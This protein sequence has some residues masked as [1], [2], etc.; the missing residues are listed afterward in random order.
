[1]TARV[2]RLAL[3]LV[4]SGAF[5]SATGVRAQS[6]FSHQIPIKV[7]KGANGIQ[8]ELALVYDPDYG[9]GIVGMGW[10]LQGLSAITRVNYGNGITY[11]DSDTY[12]HSQ[13]GILIA[14]KDASNSY[15]SKKESFSKLV[16]TG[17]CGNGPCSWVA[18]DRSG[19]K[20]YY[21]TTPDSSLLGQGK[22]GTVRTWALS[23]V[24]DLFGNNYTI[25]YQN[26]AA[27]G[28]LYPVLITYTMG[29][30]LNTYRTI[31]IQY[32]NR[33]G[34]DPGYYASVFQQMTQR[35]KWISVYSGGTLI[36]KYR[37][38]YAYTWPSQPVA[39]QEYGSNGNDSACSA[40]PPPDACALPA[41]TFA[42]QPNAPAPVGPAFTQWGDG[43]PAR[44]RFGDFNGDGKTDVMWVDGLG[45]VYILI[46]TGSGFVAYPGSGRSSNGTPLTQW[47]DGNPARYRIGD[48]N[49]DGK[50][51]VM[52]VDSLGNMYVLASTGSG[53]VAYPGS[54]R[55]SSG[56]PFTQWGDGNPDRYRFGD[57]NG[58]GKTDVM[59][60]DGV[61]NL[62]VTLSTG[63]GFAPIGH[64]QWGD[65]TP[66]RYQLGDFNGDGKT[67]V[68]WVDSLGNVYVLI[69]MGSGFV[70]YP[71]SG[72]SSNGTPF[73]QWGD[74]N[75]TRYLLGDFNGDGK[76][77]VMWVDSLGN[78][79]VLVST[80]SGF[81]AY[82]G[83]GTSSN[84][85]PFTPWGNGDP[86]RYRIGEF[87]GDGKTDLMWIDGVG[88]LNVDLSTGKGF[89]NIGSP[90]W[91]DG[92]PARY[93]LGDFNGDGTTDVV[94]VDAKGYICVHLT[95][96]TDATLASANNGMGGTV[97]VA[98]APAPQVPGAIMPL[99]IVVPG[100][101]S[102][103]SPR[104]LVTSV[105]TSDGRGGSYTTRYSYGDRRW[106]PGT[107]P[108]QR[109]LGF[110]WIT[111]VE[112]TGQSTTTVYNQDPGKE[113]TVREVRE[114][115]S[116]GMLVKRTVKTYDVVNPASGTELALETS[117]TSESYQL[118]T[119]QSNGS[120]SNFGYGVVTTTTYDSYAN[121]LTKS[122]ASEQNDLP[123]VVT[124]TTYAAPDTTNWILGRVTD[125]VVSSGTTPLR[126]QHFTWTNNSIT[127]SAN[128]WA[129]KQKWLTTSYVYDVY[130]NLLS[131]TLPQAADGAVRRTTTAYD[132]VFNAYPVTVTDAL[133]HTTRMTNGADGQLA[134]VVGPNGDTTTYVYDANWRKAV[135]TRPDGGTT[136]YVYGALGK[137]GS[138]YVSTTTSVDATHA[139][140]QTEWF[141]GSGF[142]YRKESTGPC[143]D[144]VVAIQRL[145]DAVG[146]L[147]QESA[148]Y[149]HGGTVNSTTYGYD[150]AGRLSSV[151][152]PDGKVTQY[153]YDSVARTRSRTDANGNATVQF[154]DAFERIA[155]VVDPA[156][157]SVS[158]T[159]D[160]LSNLA[161]VTTGGGATSIAYDSLGQRT[162]INVPQLGTTLF[163][164]DEVGNVVQTSRNGKTVA[165][166][167]DALNRV[168][169]KQPASEP[170]VT[171]TYDDSSHANGIGRLTSVADAAGVL[172]LAYSAAGQLATS[173][174][175]IDGAS[176][177]TASTYDQVGRITHLVYPDSSYADYSW[178][179]ATLASVSLNGAP[180]ATW[181]S[182]DPA[183]RP[184]GLTYGNQVTTTYGYDASDMGLVASLRTSRGSTDLQNNTYDWYTPPNTGGIN[185]GSIADKRAN[186][187]VG[188][189]NGDESQTFAYDAIYRLTQATGVWG[190]KAYA[191]DGLGNPT[192]FGG[193]IPRTFSFT[194]TQVTSGTGLTNVIYD[195]SGNMTH[196]TIDGIDWDY[197]WT[198]EN[199][200][201]TLSKGGAALLAM[202][203]D[204]SGERV[205][206]VYSPPGSASVT[207]HYVGDLYERRDYGDGSPQRHT[208]NVF[209]NGRLIASVTRTGSI[210]T[211]LNDGSA[212][213]MESAVASLYSWRSARG[214]IQGGLHL[215][216]AL[217]SNP[218]A[219]G[220]AWLLA[221]ASFAGW[222]LFRLAR[223]DRSASAFARAPR[224]GFAASTV[225]VVFTT[226]ACSN[227]SQTGSAPRRPLAGGAY[228]TLGPGV[229]ILY[230]HPNLVGSST[231]ITDSTGTEVER[232]S[233]LPFGELSPSNS[234]GADAV[235]R[236]FGGKEHDDEAALV[237]FGARYYEPQIGRF[238]SAD[239][240]IP[241]PL[242]LQSH[243][244]YSFVR[245]NP[246]NRVDPSG[247]DD[248]S[249]VDVSLVGIGGAAWG[250]GPEVA[251]PVDVVIGADLVAS[252]IYSWAN[253]GGGTF[254]DAVVNAVDRAVNWV[255]DLFS[256]G[257]HHR[258]SAAGGAC[259]IQSPLPALAG[260]TSPGSSGSSG[261]TGALEPA[262][263]DPSP[264]SPGAVGPATTAAA[265]GTL[266]QAQDAAR[267][268]DAFE[269]DKGLTYCNKATLAIARD[270]GAPTGPLTQA[271]GT[272]AYANT[273][274]AAL[275]T[276]TQYHEVTPMEAQQLANEGRFVIGS[277]INPNPQ[278][279]G[280]IATVRPGDVAG[281]PA[282]AGTGPLMNDIGAARWVAP[283]S[284]VFPNWLLPPRFYTPN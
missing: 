215:L 263:T 80:G 223:R 273:Q 10:Q 62:N 37:L 103:R 109:D 45:N 83:S 190:T 12:E 86:A 162:S 63:S 230:Y 283:A 186:K 179:G 188:G 116:T 225:V 120:Y 6:M 36:R 251:I 155:S 134:S 13:V 101:I 261:S 157:R 105:T 130:G 193:L 254:N 94:W 163:T 89:R 185:L 32:E 43:N 206:K 276:S 268:S 16:S 108:Q 210:V 156:S 228:A 79:Y 264:G 277:A 2:M 197:T 147:W 93:Q 40:M 192:T 260:L 50:T 203:Y 68:M 201:A 144:G 124:T 4:A 189:V 113:R 104:R 111:R 265:R 196:K 9:N 48:F 23:Q 198:V 183:G 165:F 154:I 35:L 227:G 90:Q 54:G 234:S 28:Q 204:A 118:G 257:G 11:T 66:A 253:P 39:V 137:P 61:G 26:D 117:S 176:F 110:G 72:T 112:P 229:G 97:V 271:N 77:D 187:I 249:A 64:T 95:A 125:V 143:A 122:V 115:S 81:V 270:V 178:S 200:L 208:I 182:Y 278:L 107:I 161:G 221:F 236:K 146:R 75:P 148:P 238:L 246:I 282:R 243:N 152:T 174:R 141:D 21:G 164:F 239:T 281:D 76:A 127:S 15:R 18:Y 280:H 136:T 220:V 96:A 217:A 44:Y 245:N 99:S 51:D 132:A 244:R 211:A 231:V 172:N 140:T 38:D 131:Y 100:S 267:S 25:A 84:G 240:I 1:V 135:V 17:R 167:F 222:T 171:Y 85:T 226:V 29:P 70:A 102:T 3:S 181:T 92:T 114:Y 275:A 159:Y 33:S 7:P 42:Y 30:G 168:M 55:S 150:V 58:D 59:W 191:Y 269:P 49:G 214:G 67:D 98:Y 20:Y 88:N 123:T 145:K 14:Q 74:G 212:S 209:A 252:Y 78:V 194:G 139:L 34:E 250:A 129:E 69:S 169:A 262:H 235:T 119:V 247:H 5:V 232:L 121:P 199:R 175:L 151:T 149:C 31:Q 224:L 53:F 166:Q 207:T 56:T 158:Y 153:A 46:S 248:R 195:P 106:L 128:W 52:W 126:S 87:T 202:T 177:T 82:P 170:P 47:G 279:S 27:N 213:R 256:G 242:N 8:P 22:G 241:D 173:Q 73:T 57:F 60:I 133:N 258:G 24:V 91:G 266:V 237:N 160:S 180:I 184:T 41:Q 272:A 142:V 71:G 274:A 65:G 19:M 219:A 259:G 284:R 255:D 233:Y 138:Q 205:K 216:G 218:D